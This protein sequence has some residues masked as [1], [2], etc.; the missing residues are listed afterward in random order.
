MIKIT[1]FLILSFLIMTCT[2]VESFETTIKLQLDSDIIGKQNEIITFGLPLARSSIYDINNISVFYKG[3]EQNIYIEE[4]LRWHWLDNSLRSVTIQLTNF[5]MSNQLNEAELIIKKHTHQVTRIAK[6]TPPEQGWVKAGA[7][8]FYLYYPRVF[9]LHDPFYLSTT[10]IVPPYNVIS[11]RQ[12]QLK[13][14]IGKKFDRLVQKL[15]YNA[16]TNGEWL[17][18]RSSALFKAYLNTGELTFLKEAF[19]SKQFYFFYV[20]NDQ[21][22]PAPDGG[23][24]CWQFKTVACQDGKYIYTQ[25]AKLAWALLGD[26]SQWDNELINN[27]AL[28]AD[29]GNYQYNTR[30]PIFKENQG[31]TERAAGLT[32]LTEVIAYEITADKKILGNLK[33]RINSLYQMQNMLTE[34]ENENHW[35]PKSGAFEHSW[36]VHENKVKTKNA[37]KSDTDNFRFSPWM[38]E[39]IADFL[40]HAYQISEQAK[41]ADMLQKL[42]NAIDKHGFASTYVDGEGI[43]ANY[44]RREGFKARLA[45]TG[46][47]NDAVELLYSASSVA[48]QKVIAEDHN[49]KSYT[50]QHNVEVILPLSLA[51]Y[52]SLNTNDKIRLEARIEKILSHWL[53][54]KTKDCSGSIGKN[55]RAFNW[56]Y[57]S[58]SIATWF[59]IKPQF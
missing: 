20:R 45:C 23:S 24:G 18:D 3:I 26:N 1:K 47:D 46:A 27:M 51:Y 12:P 4:G 57:R 5:D 14:L 32:G 22:K 58:N 10:D 43:N 59:W 9:A 55:L 39:N 21:T 36:L 41:I 29:L 11:K 53:D 49:K 17:F 30:T 7:D 44:L 6:K 35:T 37:K 31:F 42:G 16:S 28:Q 19:L 25:P 54:N 40:W 33:Q 8:K 13:S 50:D 52:F 38:S 2:K 34:W 48:N 15:D 56:Q